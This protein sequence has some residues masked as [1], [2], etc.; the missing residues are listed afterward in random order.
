[1]PTSGVDDAQ[2]ATKYFHLCKL[3]NDKS[4]IKALEISQKII[5]PSALGNPIVFLEEKSILGI[6]NGL[7]GRFCVG[8]DLQ[9]KTGDDGC[10]KR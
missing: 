7:P 1:M 6:K 8:S 5:L 3:K 2:S 4:G 10:C 9:T